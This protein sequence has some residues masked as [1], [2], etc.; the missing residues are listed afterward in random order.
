MWL[1]VQME[2]S[3]AQR[4]AQAGYADACLLS[5]AEG[6][7]SW[8]GCDLKYGKATTLCQPPR[9]QD[10]SKINSYHQRTLNHVSC[11]ELN[12]L[13]TLSYLISTTTLRGC[14]S[15]GVSPEKTEASSDYVICPRLLVA[16]YRIQIQIFFF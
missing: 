15:H 4:L 7:E 16:G 5:L 8:R 1:S 3:Q 13:H 10:V 11:S 12:S 6:K 2:R 14:F 9:E